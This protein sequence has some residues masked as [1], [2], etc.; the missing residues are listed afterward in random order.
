M[1]QVRKHRPASGQQS[2]E[3]KSCL[4]LE[5]YQAAEFLFLSFQLFASLSALTGKSMLST[6]KLVGSGSHRPAASSCLRIAGWGLGGQ[7][8]RIPP[9]AGGETEAPGKCS[10]TPL[11]AELELSVALTPF[12]A[13]FQGCFSFSL[14]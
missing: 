5:S 14:C 1:F 7:S 9:F 2:R 3:G 8:D 12:P 6:P 13:L 4:L 10:V 11:S